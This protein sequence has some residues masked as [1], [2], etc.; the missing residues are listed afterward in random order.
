MT[1]KII[2]HHPLPLN[3]NSPSGSGIRPVK[4]YN[5]F[6]SLGYE[7]DLVV[8]YSSERQAAIKRVL[9]NIQAGEKYLFC[10]SEASTMPLALTDIDH[11]PRSPFIDAC[12]FKALKNNK[13]KCGVFYRDIY[14]K[15][16]NTSPNSFTQKAKK[17]FAK[18]FYRLEVFTYKLFVDNVFVPSIK[19]GKYIPYIQKEKFIELN[20][21]LVSNPFV[22]KIKQENMQLLYVG[23]TTGFYNI[24]LLIEVVGK[25][26][27]ENIFLTV[28]TRPDDAAALKKTIPN[29]PDNVNVVSRSGEELL[30][31]YEKADCACLYMEPSTYREFAVPIKLFEYVGYGKPVIASSGTW[32]GHFVSEQGLGWKIDYTESALRRF[33]QQLLSNPS[34]LCAFGESVREKAHLYSWENRCIEVERALGRVK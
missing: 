32:V 12:F 24:N 5:A 17:W 31:L 15:F 7:V 13:I 30:P 28:C 20:P 4:M 22:K 2:F 10:Y 26:F 23:G 21:G 11:L 14:W 33:L 16:D 19:M 27:S 34:L 29:I 25:H 8:G 3:F 6:V 9:R 18:F 1:K